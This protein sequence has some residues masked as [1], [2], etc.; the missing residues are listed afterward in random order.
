MNWS[1]SGD[2]IFFKNEGI[3]LDDKNAE[4]NYIFH[5]GS[6]DFYKTVNLKFAEQMDILEDET[7]T[8]YI[9]ANINEFFSN[10]YTIDLNKRNSTMS[11][12][13]LAD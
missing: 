11:K 5:I 13:S 6:S 8:L 4:Q 7:T 1:W 2:Y 3:Y 10:P 12:G 9:Y